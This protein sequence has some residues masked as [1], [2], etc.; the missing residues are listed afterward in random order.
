[1]YLIF[2]S[3]ILVQC[4]MFSFF[5]GHYLIYFIINAHFWCLRMIIRPRRWHLVLWLNHAKEYWKVSIT[6]HQKPSCEILKGQVE[7]M[8]HE[9][10]LADSEDK[11][12][13]TS[14]S[15]TAISVANMLRVSYFMKRDQCVLLW[16][17]RQA[18]VTSSLPSSHHLRLNILT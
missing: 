8:K 14:L 9:I 18:D 2:F 3:P 11:M 12:N 13:T 10:R 1:M 16:P 7:P 6:K 5:D 4:N 17:L 15:L